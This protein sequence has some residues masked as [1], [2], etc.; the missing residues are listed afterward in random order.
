MKSPSTKNRQLPAPESPSR[1]PWIA[2]HWLAIFNGFVG[3]FVLGALVAPALMK[4]GYTGPASALYTLYGFT[5]HQ[6]P[7]RSYFLFGRRLM[8]PI[9]T[10]LEAWPQATDFFEQRA[11]VGDPVFGYK[12]AIANRCTAIYS[13]ILLVG[14]LFGLTRRKIRPLSMRGAFAL[15]LPMILDGG[16]HLVSEVTGLGFRDTNLWLQTLTQNTFA[17]DFYVGDMF[18]SFNWLMRTVTGA[19]FGIALVWMVYPVFRLSVGRVRTRDVQA[20]GAD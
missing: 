6:L 19:L 7:Q 13:S 9:E 10:I 3:L 17:L 5:C 18:G 12:V 11:I 8:Y 20:P 1:P 15:S 14:L 16:S 4:A 2:R